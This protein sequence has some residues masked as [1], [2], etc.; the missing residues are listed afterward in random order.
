MK[1]QEK[2]KK[3]KKKKEEE[4]K[5]KYPQALHQ[6][7]ISKYVINGTTETISSM[8]TNYYVNTLEK[9]ISLPICTK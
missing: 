7:Q 1:N 5:K 8:Y 4:K 3:K 2:K 6:T 9:Q